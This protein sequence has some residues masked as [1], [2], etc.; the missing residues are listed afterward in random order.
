M[1]KVWTGRA[2]SG[3]LGIARTHLCL[4]KGPPIATTAQLIHAVI[5]ALMISSGVDLVF[6]S[7]MHACSHE[8]MCSL[9]QPFMNMCVR[10]L[11]L[12]T[13]FR[14]KCTYLSPVALVGVVSPWEVITYVHWASTQAGSSVCACVRYIFNMTYSVISS[15]MRQSLRVL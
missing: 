11:C 1:E 10:W 8:T 4:P 12:Q 5:N 6:R 2:R 15:H 14:I 7:F 3:H 9:L 13:T